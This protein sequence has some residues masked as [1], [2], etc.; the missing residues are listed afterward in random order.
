MARLFQRSWRVILRSLRKVITID[1]NM[2]PSLMI[3]A[4]M[5]KSG[6][7]EP[8][9]CSL[10]IFG[11]DK[12]NREEFTR[13]G[14]GIEIYAGYEDTGAVMLFKGSVLWG[15]QNWNGV[16][17]SLSL[18]SV[19]GFQSVNA[20]VT[21]GPRTPYGQTI[22]T[23]RGQTTQAKGKSKPV[24]GTTGNRPTLLEGDMRQLAE[25]LGTEYGLDISV[26]DDAWSVT[27]ADTFTADDTYVIGPESGLV[28]TPTP[29]KAGFGNLIFFA[30]GWTFACRLNGHIR[31]MRRIKLVSDVVPGGSA[32]VTA[33]LVT[34][35]IQTLGQDW[36]TNVEAFN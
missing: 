25:Q 22:D 31:P 17:R 1:S 35:S 12:N 21:V 3:E 15:K 8:N 14:T 23:L 10:T 30:P 32:I 18:E 33:R 19:D 2:D 6:G 29:I 16:N 4:N 13:K 28:G 36:T 9:T 20:S 24:K 26:Q 27:P 34:H 5:S 11:L 7:F